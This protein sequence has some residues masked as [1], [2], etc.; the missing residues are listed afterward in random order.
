V[1][2]PHVLPHTFETFGLSFVQPTVFLDHEAS[3]SL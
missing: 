1:E 3:S 2:V